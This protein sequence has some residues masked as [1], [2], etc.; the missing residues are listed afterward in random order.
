MMAAPICN[1]LVFEVN[2]DG[3]KGNEEVVAEDVVSDDGVDVGGGEEPNLKEE[4]RVKK[5]LDKEAKTLPK[6]TPVTKQVAGSSRSKRLYE[7]VDSE[8]II[9]HKE[10]MDDLLR[11]LRGDGCGTTYPFHLLETKVDKYP[12]HDEDTHWRIKKPKI[13]SMNDKHTCTRSF[14][15]VTLVNYK[16]IGKNFG[17]KIGQNPQTKLHDI[18]D[19]GES[20][21]DEHYALLRTYAK[22]I[23][24]FNDGSTV[25]L[26]SKDLDLS[27]CNGLTLMSDQHK[28][29]IEAVKDVMPYAK[30]RQCARHIYKGFHKQFSG[31]QFRGLFCEASKASY[32]E[33]FNKI[34]DIIKRANPNA[35]QYLIKKIQRLGLGLSLGLVQTHVIPAGGNLFKVRNGSEAFKV[36][37]SLRKCSFC[38][39]KLS[40]IACSHDVAVIFKLNRWA[41]DYLPD[42][43][44][45]EMFIQAY[46]Q[47]LTPIDG[48]SFWPTYGESSIILP[49]K[50][51]TMPRRPGKKRIRARHET[52]SSYRV[53]R[54]AT[55]MTCQNCG[56]KGHNKAGC[57]KEKVIKPPKPSTKKGRPKRTSVEEPHIVDVLY[58]PSFVNVADV[59]GSNTPEVE[60]DNVDVGESSVAKVGG[61]CGDKVVEKRG[62]KRVK[63]TREIGGSNNSRVKLVQMRGGAGKRG[64]ISRGKPRFRRS[65]AWL[66]LNHSDMNTSNENQNS[67]H[68]HE[69]ETQK[70]QAST[71]S[72]VEKANQTTNDSAP[73]KAAPADHPRLAR[74]VASAPIRPKEKSQRTLQKKMSKNNGGAGSSRFNVQDV[75]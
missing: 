72:R 42:Y 49:H 22:V 15:Y 48:M 10:F 32:S 16:W 24:E 33:L 19:M 12:I 58:I 56:E 61:S 38:I 75:D 46:S 23:L 65:S 21:I 3:V 18:A 35:D 43:F 55:E 45:K 13:V 36:D 20:T 37:E 2:N 70:S 9:E 34:M 67:D 47:Y 44:W 62:E 28:G 71:S 17:L 41:K 4:V 30:H 1:N 7:M 60:V 64:Q 57:K 54:A 51:K 39:W 73:V 29:L 26:L 27:T 5:V 6:N 59:E 53:S 68:V 66:G 40:E 25:K 8:T 69:P 31:V 52:N 74:R 14:K 50:P 63:V 11:K